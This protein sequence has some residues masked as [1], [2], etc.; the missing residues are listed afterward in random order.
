[1]H[2][3][4]PQEGQQDPRQAVVQRTRLKAQVSLAVHCRNQEQ[5]DQPADAEQ[6]QGAEPEGTGDWLAVVEAV[7]PGEAENPQQIADHF[8][9]SVV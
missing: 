7:R 9:V 3:K 4:Y 6:A 5:V 2:A 1:M 8:A